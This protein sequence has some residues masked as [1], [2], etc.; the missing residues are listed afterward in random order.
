MNRT[1]FHK[2]KKLTE[3]LPTG[4]FLWRGGERQMNKK[5]LGI[6]VTLLLAAMFVAPVFAKRKV[7]VTATQ[8]G[9]GT[10]GE[11]WMVDHGIWQFRG[12]EGAGVV[13]LYIPGQTPL[14]GASSSVINGKITFTQEPPDPNALGIMHLKMVWTFTGKD[15]TG[16]FEGQMQR[17]GIGVPLLSSLEAHMVLQGTGDF[18]GQT[19][20]LSAEDTSL[21]PTNLVGFLSTS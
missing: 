11:G 12:T 16:T 5:I 2:R 13:T 3:K 19:L 4:T 10:G 8:M 20:M 17:K 15:T 9:G 21:P 1:I 7:A 6:A 18:K 14:V